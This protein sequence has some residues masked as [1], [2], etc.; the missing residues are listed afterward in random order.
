ME[1]RFRLE[2][3]QII[4]HELNQGADHLSLHSLSLQRNYLLIRGVVNLIVVANPIA[5]AN[6]VYIHSN[7]GVTAIHFD[8]P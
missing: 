3:Q 5:T 6:P 7:T 1:I 4:T 8:T 2:H